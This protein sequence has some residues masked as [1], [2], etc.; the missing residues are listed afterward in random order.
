MDKLIDATVDYSGAEIEQAVI[1]A[2]YDAFDTGNDLDDRGPA[3]DGARDRAA[4]DHDARDDR[5]DARVGAH[6]RAHGRRRAAARRRRRRAGWRATAHRPRTSATRARSPT[7]TI[8]SSSCSGQRFSGSRQRSAAAVSGQRQPTA[9]S[10]SGSGQRQPTA[11]SGSDSDSG[12]AAAESGT[13]QRRAE[14]V[15]GERNRSAA[16]SPQ[17]AASRQWVSLHSIARMRSRR[18]AIAASSALEMMPRASAIRSAV[19]SSLALPAARR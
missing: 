6:A 4:R 13:G 16:S 10:G 8:G 3:Q 19:V 14:P 5:A 2:L 12:T 1:A 15:S 7:T 11:V 9:V 17:L 18:G